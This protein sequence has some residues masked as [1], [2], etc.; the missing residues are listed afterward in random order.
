[1]GNIGMTLIYIS[2]LYALHSLFVI[3]TGS[4]RNICW[5]VSFILNNYS[6][7]SFPF[8]YNQRLFI[9]LTI[10]HTC[11]ALKGLMAILLIR[12]V[13]IL[14][15]NPTWL[16][17]IISMSMY[18]YTYTYMGR[19]LNKFIIHFLLNFHSI[20]QLRYVLFPRNLHDPISELSLFSI[21]GQ[22]NW[23]GGALVWRPIDF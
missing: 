22:L 2:T 12:Q 21:Y 17:V 10:L 6:D 19:R 11:V 1:M 3:I 15:M 18:I 16:T 5:K 4:E 8:V 14:T 7:R 23:R 9:T 13:Y 20:T